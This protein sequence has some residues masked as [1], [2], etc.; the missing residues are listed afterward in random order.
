MSS[1]HKEEGA[2]EKA[3][4]DGTM[5]LNVKKFKCLDSIIQHN[6]D[7]DDD[8]SHCAKE[9]W[10]KW[11]YASTVLW[12]KKISIKLKRKVFHIMVRL[13]LVYKTNQALTN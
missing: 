8:I 6:G 9:Q 13:L 7:M 12:D 2:V 1:V 10:Q 11:T 4:L 5:A 3:V